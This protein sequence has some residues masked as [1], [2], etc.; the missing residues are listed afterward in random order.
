M[1]PE[2]RCPNQVNTREVIRLAKVF[3]NPPPNGLE[4]PGFRGL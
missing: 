2:I 3:E 4:K 1:F